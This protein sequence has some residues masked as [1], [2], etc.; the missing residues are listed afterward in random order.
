MLPFC[1]LYW[2][3]AEKG[4]YFQFQVLPGIIHA[5]QR[6]MILRP[7]SPEMIANPQPLITVISGTVL[8]FVVSTTAEG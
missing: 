8:M 1:V 3:C 2:C 5:K 7:V 6:P 4:H